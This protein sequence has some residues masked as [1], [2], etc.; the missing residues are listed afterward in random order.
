MNLAQ[1]VSGSATVTFTLKDNYGQSTTK[2]ILVTVNPLIVPS[3]N[4][5]KDLTV[6]LGKNVS[7]SFSVNASGPLSS[8]KATSSDTS[9]L[10]QAQVQSGVKCNMSTKACTYSWTPNGSAG[11]T[12]VTINASDTFGQT[13]KG[14]FKLTVNAVPTA[15]GGGG[16]GGGGAL[17]EWTLMAL[18]VLTGA[19]ARKRRYMRH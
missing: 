13:A 12:T 19:L 16:G 11:T 15:S 6:T 8:V 5:L 9:V 7:G 3:I 17:G 18:A 2:S 1:G 4:G 14:S 10:T